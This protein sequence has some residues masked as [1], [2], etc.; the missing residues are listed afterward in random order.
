MRG[1]QPQQLLHI[2]L[3]VDGID[4]QAGYG[5]VCCQIFVFSQLAE[6]GR[7]Q[8]LDPAALEVVVSSVERMLP[9]GIEFG[10]QDGLIH[11]HPFHTLGRQRIQ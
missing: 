7:Q 8:Q 6:I 1:Q 3:A 2:V 5:Q 4:V 10:D 11:L 9:V